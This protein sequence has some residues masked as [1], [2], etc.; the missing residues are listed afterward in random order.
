MLYFARRLPLKVGDVYTIDR[1]YKAD[2]NPIVLRVV[3]R[4]TVTVP[5]GTFETIVV[6]PTI[7]TSGLFGEGGEAELFFSDDQ[8][9]TLVQMRSKVPLI[10]SLS[11]H[12]RQYVPPPS[13]K[14]APG[15]QQQ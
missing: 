9:H 11:L 10:G 2:A 7:K 8:Y 4:E 12:L 5:A 1:Y 6:R 15:A 3:R 13:G 14:A